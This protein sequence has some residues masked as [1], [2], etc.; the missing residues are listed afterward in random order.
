MFMLSTSY[1]STEI[2]ENHYSD[3]DVTPV[4]VR[5]AVYDGYGEGR[6]EFL[7]NDGWISPH[8]FTLEYPWNFLETPLWES[9]EAR[10]FCKLLGYEYVAV[11]FWSLQVSSSID[12]HDKWE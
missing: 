2:C 9:P 1:K 6:V 11:T 12:K 8:F 4:R 5:D 7:R 3:R 10:L